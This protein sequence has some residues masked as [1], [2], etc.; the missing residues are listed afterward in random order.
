MVIVVVGLIWFGG[1]YDMFVVDGMVGGCHTS[2]AAI[3]LEWDG[4]FCLKVGCPKTARAG[5]W[6]GQVVLWFFG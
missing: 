3:R 6:L 4:W 2:V 1:L 5:T